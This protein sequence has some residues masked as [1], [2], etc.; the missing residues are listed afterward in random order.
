MLMQEEGVLKG[1]ELE[2]AVSDADYTKA[3]EL[4]L[5]LRRPHKLFELF[6]ELCRSVRILSA[7]SGEEVC[8][9]LEYIREWNAKPKLCHVA[10]S[11]LSQVFRILSP[12]EIVE[13]KGIGELL[14][15]LIPYSQRHFSRIDRLVRSTYLLDYTLTGMSVIEPEVD[16]SAVN[17]GSPDKSGLEK[18]EDGLLGENVGEE[19]NQ[20][21]EELESSAYK[22]RKLPRSKDRSKKKSKDVVYADAAAI[23]FRA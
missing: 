7:L 21:K 3:I 16:R 8:L 4:A 20:N 10:Q 18:L 1:Q 12:T 9:L 19:K 14:E 11:V 2:N 23:S 5:E 22:K 6:S 17:D 15:G 13:I